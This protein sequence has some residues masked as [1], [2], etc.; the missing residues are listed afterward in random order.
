MAKKIAILGGRVIQDLRQ[1]ERGRAG[2]GR[3]PRQRQAEGQ[4]QREKAPWMGHWGCSYLGLVRF[5]AWSRYFALT[6]DTAQAIEMKWSRRHA[7]GDVRGQQRRFLPVRPF[8]F[9]LGPFGV[10]RLAA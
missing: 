8:V 2:D 5:A 3:A 6:A 1:A 9:E 4:Q 7:Y 10:R